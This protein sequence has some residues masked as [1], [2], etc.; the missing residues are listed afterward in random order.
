MNKTYRNALM[1]ALYALLFLVV[2]VVQTAVF[3]RHRF[4]GAKLSL[5]PVAIA[6]VTMHVGHEPGAIFALAASLVWYWTGADG[7]SVGIVTLTVTGIVAGYLCDA[8]YARRLLPA[9][10]LSL[11]A[12]LFH[13][14]ALFLIKYYLNEADLS[15]W[16]WLPI[17]VGLAL[18]AGLVIF[19]LA[20]AIRKAGD[21]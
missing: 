1:W 9:L 12:V 5:I 4:W 17:Q 8:V 6:C 21:V 10:C 20:K 2:M 13:E 18:P 11:G 16:R 14:G 3:G 15:L 7:G 19:P